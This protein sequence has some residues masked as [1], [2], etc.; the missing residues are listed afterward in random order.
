MKS[1]TIIAGVILPLFVGLLHHEVRDALFAGRWPTAAGIVLGF[2]GI[3]ALVGGMFAAIFALKSRLRAALIC[4]GIATVVSGALSASSGPIKERIESMSRAADAQKITVWNHHHRETQDVK[5]TLSTCRITKVSSRRLSPETGNRLMASALNFKGSLENKSAEKIVAV[6][7]DMRLLNKAAR[8]QALAMPNQVVESYRRNNPS[9][10]RSDD[11]ITA[12]I[13]EKYS[14]KYEGYEDF[15][16][17]LRR[18]AQQRQQ[19]QED[20]RRAN[21]PSLEKAVVSHRLKMPIV[22]FPTATVSIDQF[23]VPSGYEDDSV[24]D[25]FH[26]ASEQLGKTNWAWNYELVA[27]IPQ[28][29]E[30]IDL[31]KILGVE[32]ELTKE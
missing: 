7:I 18:L 32:A 29:L 16:S 22:V 5:F 1:L 10:T 19:A 14:G 2:N 12:Y 27:I 23:Y 28:S 11:E 13:G 17:D 9:D 25:E 15:A 6:V 24:I 3:F 26:F 30:D 21:A 20:K 31:R 8:P 4:V